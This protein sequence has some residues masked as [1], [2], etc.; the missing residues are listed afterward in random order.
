[1]NHPNSAVNL[2]EG[3]FQSF[4]ENAKVSQMLSSALLLSKK[5]QDTQF[6]KWV[7]LEFNGY[8]NTNP[9]LTEE[10]IVPE[11][12]TVVGHYHDRWGRPIIFNDP[13]MD[14]IN[15]YRLRNGASEIESIATKGGHLQIMDSNFNSLVSE[16]LNVEV[17]YFSF[18][19]GTVYGILDAIKE[20]L[21]EKLADIEGK[22]RTSNLSNNEELRSHLRG[23][24]INN[25]FEKAL[26]SLE[27]TL[28]DAVNEITLHKARLNEVKQNERLGFRS[29]ADIE[30]TKIRLR[31][32]ILELIEKI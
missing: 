4:K 16:H 30:L 5:V 14:F 17:A 26:N 32:A 25:D 7:K 11:Y 19:T 31:A 24:L 27:E 10:V 21:I 13:Q 9:A 18:F 15:K 1:M 23:L 12:R 22:I 29:D 6:E 8:F 28:P 20:S 3:I 2:L